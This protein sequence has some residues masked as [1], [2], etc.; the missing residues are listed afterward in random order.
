MA[1]Y[2]YTPTEQPTPK[3]RRV[4]LRVFLIVL[5]VIV[6]FGAAVALLYKPVKYYSAIA[7]YE[8]QLYELAEVQFDALSGYKD[9]EFFANRSRYEQAEQAYWAG[10]YQA[11]IEGFTALGDF[12]NSPHRL[13]TCYYYLGMKALSDCEYETALAHLENAGDYEDAADY[14]QMAVYEWGHSLFLEGKYE[15]ADEIFA[16]LNGEY[17]EYG[18][19]HF[20]DM[21]A[22]RAYFTAEAQKLSPQIV[23][24][25]G[26]MPEHYR[27]DMDSLLNAFAN[28]LPCQLRAVSYDWENYVFSAD[29]TYYPSDRMLYAWRTGDETVLLEG[30]KAV[31][32]RAVALV[33][34]AYSETG[35][36]LGLE[37]WLHDWLCENVKYSNP[38]M[39]VPTEEYLALRELTC[40]GAMQDGLA[41]CQGYTDA[42]YLLG[43]IG[44]LQVGRLSGIADEPHTWNTVVLEGKKYIVDV[45]FDD[46]EDM[47]DQARYYAWFNSPYDPEERQLYGGEE[48]CPDLTRQMDWPVTYYGHTGTIFATMDEAAGYMLE[49]YAQKGEG[50]THVVLEGIE[51]DS[52]DL[53][54]AVDANMADYDIWSVRWTSVIQF[55]YGNT[56]MSIYWE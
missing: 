29:V 4:G 5:S 13:K 53:Y 18:A 31:L 25:I 9:A 23:C 26:Q 39:D 12:E 37:I 27:D 35:G 14:R 30:E 6:V 22:A 21:E 43:T 33:E 8:G 7:L 34:L 50:W 17:P 46:V 54:E 56:Y 47:D 32:D 10:D 19:P 3:K 40:V 45:T 41:N 55:E 11:A 16:R 44:G 42:F 51:A 49:Q 15:A 2:D 24:F 1:P 52:D 28:Y 36:D 20:A 38:D 48:T